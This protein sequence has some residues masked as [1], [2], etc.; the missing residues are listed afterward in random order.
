MRRLV[1][2]PLPPIGVGLGPLLPA[3]SVCPSGSASPSTRCASQGGPT[4]PPRFRLYVTRRALRSKPGSSSCASERRADPRRGLAA[5]LR[6]SGD[7][8]PLAV[9]D[10]QAWLVTR[11]FD[12]WNHHGAAGA[13]AWLSEWVVLEDPPGWPDGGRWSGREAAIDR[14]ERVTA[15]LGGRWIHVADAQSFGE[16]VLVTGPAFGPGPDGQACWDLSPG[17]RGPA[18]GNHASAGFPSARGG[19]RVTRDTRRGG[20]PIRI[21][22]GRAG[23]GG[24]D[25]RARGARNVAL[26]ARQKSG[27]R[28]RRRRRRPFPRALQVFGQGVRVGWAGRRRGVALLGGCVLLRRFASGLLRAAA[29]RSSWSIKAPHRWGRPGTG[30]G[31]LA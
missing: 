8:P 20:K 12:A 4:T 3:P 19:S 15:E 11:G 14:L 23:T 18:G 26:S 29:R 21:S 7:E 10:P 17:R 27:A 16:E 5:R 22:G 30:R 9:T 28:S 13:A 31:A 24:T 2:L 25:P 1:G 6:A